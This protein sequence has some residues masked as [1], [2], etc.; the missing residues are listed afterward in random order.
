MGVQ[1]EPQRASDAGVTELL[2]TADDKAEVAAA[3][4]E[5]DA[6]ELESALIEAGMVGAAIRTLEEWDEHPHALATANLP[7]VSAEQIG[8]AVF[9]VFDRNGVPQL[10]ALPAVDPGERDVD[11]EALISTALMEFIGRFPGAPAS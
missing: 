4:A 8:D 7:L 5:R 6:V 10:L 1:H 9:L 3:I 11:G 2:G